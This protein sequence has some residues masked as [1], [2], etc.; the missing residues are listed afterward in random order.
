MHVP[1]L[2]MGALPEAGQK[3]FLGRGQLGPAL[4]NL[5]G[6]FLGVQGLAAITAFKGL[7][8]YGLGAMGAFLI[9]II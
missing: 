4:F 2:A 8:L 3:F 5:A 7:Q 1:E 9:F 6:D